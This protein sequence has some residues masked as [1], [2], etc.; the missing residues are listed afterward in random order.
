MSDKTTK[1]EE[2]QKFVDMWVDGMVDEYANMPFEGWEGG[3]ITFDNIDDFLRSAWNEVNYIN[4]CD[5]QNPSE[6]MWEAI[7]NEIQWEPG[8]FDK[9]SDMHWDDLVE[10][11]TYSHV[12]Y[13]GYGF[14]G[15]QKKVWE[16]V[17][18][19]A[20]D[21]ARENEIERGKKF[22]K[23]DVMK[24][25][26][27]AVEEFD[28]MSDC[29]R[30]MWYRKDFKGDFERCNIS[31]ISS[32]DTRLDKIGKIGIDDDGDVLIDLVPAKDMEDVNVDA[33]VIEMIDKIAA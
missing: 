30:R 4:D 3:D 11:G 14:F 18:S 25:L 29:K 27:D 6:Q 31:F 32:C 19:S 8:E 33:D 9:F 17:E 1:Y 7:E 5:G 15:F 2:V 21:V 23:G 10:W 13:E 12:S 16:A 28:D 26:K 20:W 22:S 24:F